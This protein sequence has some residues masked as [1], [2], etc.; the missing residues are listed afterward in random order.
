MC[1]C[2]AR[3]CACVLFAECSRK[4][5]KFNTHKNDVTYNLK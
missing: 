4:R 1:L 2:S 3:A 5:T